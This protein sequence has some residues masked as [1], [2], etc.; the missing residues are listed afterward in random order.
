[1]GDAAHYAFISRVTRDRAWRTGVPT[2]SRSI[3]RAGVE[4]RFVPAP[5]RDWDGSLLYV[6]R[7]DRR[8]GIA[9]AVA[10]LD[11]LPGATLVVVGDGPDAPP[12]H[13]RMR[14]LE[15]VPRADLPGWYASCDAVVFPVEWEEPWG[16]VPLEAMACGRPVVAT[17]RG[18]SGEYLVDGENC[19][20]FESAAG[21]AERVEALAADVALRERLVER[22]LE[23]AAGLSAATVNAQIERRLVGLRSSSTRTVDDPR[24][25]VF[26]G[27]PTAE[28]RAAHEAVHARHPQENVAVQGAIRVPHDPF[29]RWWQRKGD[30]P[31]P[32]PEAGEVGTAYLDLR[33]ASF[34]R[35]FIDGKDLDV[36]ALTERGLR[37][38]FLPHPAM[39][40]GTTPDHARITD[41]QRLAH[42]RERGPARGRLKVLVPYIPERTPI[43]GRRIWQSATDHYDSLLARH[44]D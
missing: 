34:K 3:V 42:A 7:L 32:K 38:H 27:E 13:P 21:L 24:D 25:L 16:L 6:G 20:L 22:G 39:R 18:G 15:D 4:D 9:T 17:G 29:N 33:H 19:L 30:P 43:I 10:A 31:L 11:L 2:P 26:F 40:A 8:K 14:V 1:M 36:H 35:A 44:D 5:P 23:T 12:P 41:P 37:L 28:M